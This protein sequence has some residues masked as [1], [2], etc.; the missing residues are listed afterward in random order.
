MKFTRRELP[1]ALAS[2]AALTSAAALAQTPAPRRSPV[3]ELESARSQVKATALLLQQQEVPM[4]TEPA[5]A[6]H[7]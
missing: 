6:F 7:A 2:V 4:S 5:F 3:A 1:A